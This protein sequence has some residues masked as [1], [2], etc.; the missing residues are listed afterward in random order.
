MT[1][2][3]FPITNDQ[4]RLLVAGGTR[5]HFLLDT[6]LPRNFLFPITNDQLRL[7]VAGGTC[8]HFLLDTRLPRRRCAWFAHYQLPTA[9]SVFFCLVAGDTCHH[10]LLTH[11]YTL[12]T[13]FYGCRGAGAPGSPGR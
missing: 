4:L 11:D 13:S 8:H 9:D 2:S 3:L 12:L 1:N 6:R 7:L 5:H 10:F